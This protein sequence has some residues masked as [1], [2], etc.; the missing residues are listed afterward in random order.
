MYGTSL[1]TMLVAF[2]DSDIDIGLFYK[3]SQI[4]AE[5]I[6]VLTMRTDVSVYL[7]TF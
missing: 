6:E 2:F 5:Y 7:P 1:F 4:H 3:K